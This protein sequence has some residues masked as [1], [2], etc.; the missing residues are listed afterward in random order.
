METH[1][2]VNLKSVKFN[3]DEIAVLQRTAS[4][5]ALG[6]NW[7]SAYVRGCVALEMKISGESLAGLD[8][9]G[10]VTKVHAE[11]FERLKMAQHAASA[12]REKIRGRTR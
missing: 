6:K 12:V 8:I 4:R 9:P 7:F 5:Y 2:K 1:K 10:W 11:T 3:D